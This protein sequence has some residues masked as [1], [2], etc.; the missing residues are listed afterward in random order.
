MSLRCALVAGV[1]DN[2]P[3]GE[4]RRLAPL[5]LGIL[6]G[7]ESGAVGDQPRLGKVGG[8]LEGVEQQ[9]ESSSTVHGEEVLESSVVGTLSAS[10]WQRVARPWSYFDEEYLYDELATIESR[11]DGST[12]RRYLVT[13][14]ANENRIYP[15][16]GARP[17]GPARIISRDSILAQPGEDA[18]VAVSLWGY[19]EWDVPLLPPVELTTPEEWADALEARHLAIDERET[20]A[21]N[22][23]SALATAVTA[24]GGELLGTR[25]AIGSAVLRI[26]K[27]WLDELSLRNDVFSIAPARPPYVDG[28]DL[29]EG[30]TAARTGADDFINAGFAGGRTNAGRHAHSNIL[31]AQ[32]ESTPPED[33]A[34]M[35]FDGAGCT[36]TNRLIGKYRCDGAPTDE[37]SQEPNFTDAEERDHPTWIAN[38]LVGDYTDGQADGVR[39]GDAAWTSGAHSS[40]WESD[41]TGFAPEASLVFYGQ[42]GTN[43][44][45]DGISDAIEEI[46]SIWSAD[47][48][49]GSWFMKNDPTDCETDTTWD[50]EDAFEVAFDDGVFMAQC[51]GNLS[52]GGACNVA[53]PSDIPKAFAVGTL[54]SELAA[55]ETTYSPNCTIL[56]GASAKGGGDSIGLGG[57]TNSGSE[58]M[59]DLVAPGNLTHYTWD[60][61]DTGV[62]AQPFGYVDEVTNQFGC[63]I[64]TP[65][66]A[67]SAALVKDQFLN[68]GLTYINSPGRLHAVMLGMG[69]RHKSAT[70][71]NAATTTTQLSVGTD[72]FFGL[73]RLN[74]RL[75]AAGTANSPFGRSMRTVSF[76]T[77]SSADEQF[78]FGILPAGVVMFKCVMN[79]AEDMSGAKTDISDIDLTVTVRDPVCSPTCTCSSLGNLVVSSTDASLDSKSMVA[80]DNITL[81]GQCVQVKLN[82]YFVTSAG[83][84]VN[85]FCYYSAAQ[86]DS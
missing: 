74:L 51:V 41:A 61:V 47:I 38:I 84:T 8:A 5:I 25:W 31:I 83:V 86:D 34:C 26:P 46:H 1:G 14:R 45:D 4:S 3:W 16:E 13:R 42:L 40:T 23:S 2:L 6:A 21:D 49:N 70:P 39:C 66:V 48:Y 44:F 78:P 81:A 65:V 20:L 10:V 7:C 18:Y 62:G 67:G 72:P 33:E 69:D 29:G 73:G 53:S 27:I 75:L 64:A 82:P 71:T 11:E 28:W 52:I 19:P 68:D 36:G 54:D 77:A 58:S 57:G 43:S 79:Q 9:Y 60:G 56:N 15:D 80:F 24:A 76:T 17:P 32:V 22:F 35:F 30:R 55:C 12:F 85:A 59:I 37:C 50:V 63:S